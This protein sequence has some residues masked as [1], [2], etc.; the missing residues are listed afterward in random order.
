MK[1]LKLLN[2]IN[3]S[4][5]ISFFFLQNSY[6]TEPIDIW[7]I[8]NQTIQEDNIEDSI[9]IESENVL[10]ESIF[11]VTQQKDNTIKIDEEK[12]LF[13][14]N[15]NIVGIYDPADHDLSMYMWSY[16]NGIKILELI[17]K[18]NNIN[19]SQDAKE[20]LN[21]ALL[22]NSYFPKKNISKEQ[23]LK[24]KSDWLIR[25]KDFNLIESYF[26][27]NNTLE[28][29]SGLVKY[30]LDYYLSRSDLGKSCD[31]FNKINFEIND[32]YV[33][34]FKI[35]CYISENKTEEAQLLLD[36]LKEDG[37]NDI[38]FE[39]K[40]SYLIGYDE[41]VA[42]EIS[43]KSLLDFHLSHRTD[44][45]F[46]FEPKIDTSKL[47]WK[48]LSYSNLLESID[49]IDLED[50]E[51][52]LTVEMAT[53]EKNY[54]EEELFDL[55]ER[56]KF[57]INQLLTV[58]ES[59]KL[60]PSSESRALVYQGILI[61]KEIPEKIKL[62]KILK[63][64][65]NKDKMP[66]AF[67]SKLVEFL[68][69]I[70]ENEIPSDYTD[71]YN[72]HKKINITKKNKDI[73]FNN[74]IIHQ[75]KILNYFKE[76]SDS[77]SVEKDLVNLFKK[78]KKDKKYFFSMKDLIILESLKSDGIEFPKKTYEYEVLAPNIPYD[79]QLLINREEPGLA[80]LRL[81]EIIGEDNLTEIGPDTIYFIV[82]VLNQLNL[83]K[84][85][86]NILLKVLP[87]KV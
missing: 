52:L 12:N 25:Q 22:T 36:I 86:N 16:S 50:K 8:D 30:Y 20:I 60:L 5:L 10:T 26:S 66:E 79:I 55:Y 34:K 6:S 48:Y 33:L 9:T 82:S 80:L 56:F 11:Q 28:D 61:T 76:E 59:Y 65:F 53:H 81:V 74:K 75:S 3:L 72:S 37:F 29:V 15:T 44:P 27:K 41:T 45:N 13:T 14:K 78:I 35:Y 68:E 47:I 19:L 64:L 69:T 87:L 85:R 70:D 7:K 54:K 4:I 67:D 83:D 24:I 46:K 84:I 32:D 31:I 49:L 77:K 73:Q 42:K 71:F 23:F 62:I 18:I 1:I 2:K 57:N 63:D 38:F 40:F 17:D 21:I 51:K 39:K 58:E 43:E